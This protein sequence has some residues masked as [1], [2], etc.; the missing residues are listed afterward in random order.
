MKRG[1]MFGPATAERILRATC[2]G[3]V[4][5]VVP[6]IP[7]GLNSTLYHFTLLEDMGAT[8]AGNAL[9][10][11]TSANQNESLS[12]VYV[13][14]I[15][16]QFGNLTSGSVG[17][18][19]R[20]DDGY[21]VIHPDRLG[22]AGFQLTANLAINGTATATVLVSN[23]PVTAIT[24]QSIGQASISGAKGVAVQLG[25]G[26]WTI[27][28][29]EQYCL[30]WAAAL[31]GDTH[32][33]SPGGSGAGSVSDKKTTLSYAAP[34]FKYSTYPYS[35]LP[36][37]APT[38]IDNPF[39]LWGKENDFGIFTFRH[40]IFQPNPNRATLISVIPR[41]A[42]AF[43]YELTADRPTGRTANLTAKARGAAGLG[44][45]GDMPASPS[46]NDAWT[47]VP[48]QKNGQI[49]LAVY[50]FEIGA[51][52][53]ITGQRQASRVKATISP[54]F[55]GT[56]ATFTVNSAVGLDGTS[57]SGTITVQNRYSWEAGTT[58]H[59]IEIAWDTVAGEWYPVQM[60]CPN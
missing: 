5:P 15:L 12:N 28:E 50:D 4:P 53:A 30:L 29:I 19:I 17:W 13:S 3:E 22:V 37:V 27:V 39:N 34:I 1:V 24:V 16:S 10:N 58:G 55:S 31:A 48:N 56:P 25:T 35:A 32:N 57:P 23:L 20:E 36:A 8:V 33:F 41:E 7:M 9:A 51:Y 11:V 47:N 2:P 49:G 40:D 21:H 45:G 42:R 44:I 26:P 43:I 54:S 59:P 14:D 18:C 46:I 60:R 38:D 52:K 6:P